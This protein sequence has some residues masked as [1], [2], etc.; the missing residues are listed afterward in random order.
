MKMGI[1]MGEIVNQIPFLQTSTM[2]CCRAAG[3][4]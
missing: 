3:F 4:I 1:G 2:R